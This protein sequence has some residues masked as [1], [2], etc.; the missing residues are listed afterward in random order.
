MWTAWRRERRRG[1]SRRRELKDHRM[2]DRKLRINDGLKDVGIGSCEL[3]TDFF[4]DNG[5]T[6]VDCFT[7][8]GIRS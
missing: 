7:D 3:Y 4:H 2:A 1:W 6:N 5:Q 8:G